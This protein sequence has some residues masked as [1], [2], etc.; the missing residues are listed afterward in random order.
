[1]ARI[2]QIYWSNRKNFRD[3]YKAV[4]SEERGEGLHDFLAKLSAKYSYV[5]HPFRHKPTFKK[6]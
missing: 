2:L 4:T 3:W 6:K 1:M 5:P